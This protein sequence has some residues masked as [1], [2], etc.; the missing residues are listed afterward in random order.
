MKLGYVILIVAV[1]FVLRHIVAT[2][3][4]VVVVVVVVVFIHRAGTNAPQYQLNK[5]ISLQQFLELAHCRVGL[6]Q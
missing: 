1:R 5:Q 3:V 2:I 4:V 6:M